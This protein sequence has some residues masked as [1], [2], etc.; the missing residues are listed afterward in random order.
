MDQSGSG[1][2][3]FRILDIRLVHNFETGG[4]VEAQ[5]IRAE[6]RRFVVVHIVCRRPEIIRKEILRLFKVVHVHRDVLDV[7][8]C[9]PFILLIKPDTQ[10]RYLKPILKCRYSLTASYH[11]PAVQAGS[12][13]RG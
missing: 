10:F 8:L 3:F 1:R 7:H 2:R 6:A 5:E 4:V 13:C 11:I 9:S 12:S